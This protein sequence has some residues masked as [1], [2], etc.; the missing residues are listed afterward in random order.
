MD[1]PETKK[2]NVCIIGKVFN[3]NFSKLLQLNSVLKEYFNAVKWYLSFDSTSKKWL[4]D[5]AYES[6]KQNFKLKTALIQSARDKA[7]EILKSF[8][9]CKKK[10]S[11]LRLKYT[12][13]RF[14]ERSYTFSKTTNQLTPF[15]LSLS[16]NGRGRTSFPII[17]GK[18]QED[19]IN[20]AIVGD[21]KFKSVEM[22]KKNGVWYAHFNLEREVEVSKTPKTIIGIDRGEKNFA[23]GVAVSKKNPDKPIKGQFWN[24]SR[25]KEL[26]GKYHHIRRS[27]GR[28]EKPQMIKK[29]KDKLKKRTDHQLHILANEI[30]AYAEQFE[31]S[32]IVME[33]LTHI[34]NNFR[35]H[36]RPKKLNRRMNSLPFRKLQDY[37]EY[38]ALQKGIATVYVNPKNTSKECHRCGQLN[39]IRSSR[40]YR[41]RNCGM[42]YDRD[43]NASINI[44]Q[45]VTSSLGWG[46]SEPPELSNEADLVKSGGT[47]EAHSF[48]CG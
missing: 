12:T 7:V 15:W 30:V 33:N 14:D 32:L 48:R 24:G 31:N 20:R 1:V 35:K 25:I 16:L 46:S 39:N 6:A 13:I 2:L 9:K 44:A 41:C 22:S 28:K 36:R 34:R 47:G 19:Y 45:R 27:L 23:V 11:K 26:K 42:I 18:R 38:K 4:H 37:I 43:L 40:V 29:I 8:R 21:Y 17:F 10:D 5:N 3:P